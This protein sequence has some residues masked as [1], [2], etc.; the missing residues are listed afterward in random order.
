MTLNTRQKN[1]KLASYKLQRQCEDCVRRLY[2]IWPMQTE[3]VKCVTSV[4]K[5]VFH[6]NNQYKNYTV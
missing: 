1:S 2:S 6:F 4:I 5:P 3:T